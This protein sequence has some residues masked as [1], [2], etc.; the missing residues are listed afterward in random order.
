MEGILTE[1]NTDFNLSKF[2]LETCAAITKLMAKSNLQNS[3]SAEN[4]ADDDILTNIDCQYYNTKEFSACKFKRAKS[5][6][7]LHLNIH[8]ITRHIEELQIFLL[9][10]NFLFDII[11]ITESKIQK[12][13]EPIV[14]ITLDGYHKPESM[15]TE[16]TKGGVL[17]YVNK[18]LDYKPRMDLIIYKP[19]QLES[20]FIEVIN[21]KY[22]NDII[23]VI[24]RHPCMDGNEFTDVFLPKLMD[25]LPRKNK[26]VYLAGDW[27][28]DLTNVDSNSETT[29]FFDIMMD[30]SLLPSISKPTKINRVKNTLID[31]IF[32]NNLN[33]E[34]KTG[35]ICVNF[36]DGHLPSFLIT[37]RPNQQHLPKKHNIMTR[38]FKQ[39]NKESFLA[40]FNSVNWYGAMEAGSQDANRST[41]LFL[42]KF[43]NILDKHVPLK[44]KSNK[45]FKQSFKP[46]INNNILGNIK[47]KNKVFKKYME[48]KKRKA[49][50]DQT[51]YYE[52]FKLLKNQITTETRKCKKEYYRRFFERHSKDL[53]EVWKGIKSIININI[54]SFESPSSIEDGSGVTSDPKIIATSFNT[55]FTTIADQILQKRKYKGSKSYRDYLA[56]RMLQNFTFSACDQTEI[57]AI[58]NSFDANKSSGPNSIPIKVLKLVSQEISYPLMLIFNISLSTGVHPDVLKLTKTVPIYKKGSRLTISNYRP[59][60]LLS[61]I[62]KILE[63]IIHSRVEKFLEDNKCL[64]SLQFGFRRSHSTNHALVEITENIRKALD[65]KE[66]TAAVFVDL[67]KAFDTVNHEIILAKLEHYGIRNATNDWF[68]SY[69]HNRTQYVS[70]NGIDSETETI[71]HGVPQGSVLGPLLFLIYINDLNFAIKYSKVFHFAD[72]TN[73][74]HSSKCLRTLKNQMNSD[75]NTLF[76]WLHANMISLN[77]D[78]T[79]FVIFHKTGTQR[80]SIF[81]KMGGSRINPSKYIKYLGILID[82]NLNFSAHCSS[83]LSK[84]RRANGMLSKARHYINT[85]DLRSLYYSLYS[86]HLTYA[87]QVW[88]QMENSHTKAIFQSQKRAIRTI[89]FSNFTA[90]CQP[91]FYKSKILTLKDHITLLNVTFTKKVMSNELP[92]PDCFNTYFTMAQELYEYDTRFASSGSLFVPTWRRIP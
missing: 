11:C 62:N 66:F 83:L 38:D 53:R 1:N 46:W 24:Y 65:N 67:Q 33:P 89:N 35:N 4:E 73:L 41:E 75:L 86:S 21:K 81:L 32:T 14:D 58:V 40:E 31:N 44:K 84:L 70:I 27:N 39:F 87:C 51:Y 25:K 16:A 78:K 71:R 69:L 42:A 77:T 80:P 52:V 56:N 23:G 19:K 76:Q 68:R 50:L 7:I 54:N 91:L 12:D 29:T 6:S 15:P 60:S 17:L 82:E 85:N 74:L 64:Y 9:L 63:K 90:H 36:S 28:F 72:D 55:Y 13:I 47:T 8:S 37:P 43:N 30:N 61:N 3:D 2:Q 49:E 18:E 57:T 10:V 48:A 34:M 79:G 26:K 22:T 5:F 92:T 88:G 45:Q 20:M 59:I